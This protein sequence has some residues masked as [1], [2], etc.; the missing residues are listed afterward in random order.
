M[1][2]V[3]YQYYR[4][5]NILDGLIQEFAKR[6]WLFDKMPNDYFHNF[7]WPDIVLSD[8]EHHFLWHENKS[9]QEIEKEFPYT[10]ELLGCY[11]SVNSAE[12]EGLVILYI[13]KIRETALEF[14]KENGM[15]QNELPI[16]NE[17]L[18]T[19]IMIHEFTHWIFHA[20]PF[21]LSNNLPKQIDAF[22][23]NDQDSVSYH[24]TLAQIF[25]N[26]FSLKSPELNRL[27]KWLENKQPSVYRNYRLLISDKLDEYINVSEDTIQRVIF[28]VMFTGEKFEDEN[29]SY[30]TL[31][32]VYDRFITVDISEFYSNPVGFH[33]KY[34]SVKPGMKFGI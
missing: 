26:Y 7:R 25:T 31:K 33:A 27:F 3:F 22:K 20:I 29:Q 2:P 28:S 1:N 11:Q 16:Y 21:T 30:K 9:Q 8:K 5:N 32:E 23:Y 6:N 10:I 18:T 4:E 13:P 34:R 15:S 19:L 14:L 12:R 24:E 17:L